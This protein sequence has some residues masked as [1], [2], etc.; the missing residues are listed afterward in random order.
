LF[1]DATLPPGLIQAYRETHYKVPGLEL[2]LVIDQ[3][4]PALELAHH[5]HRADCSA[6]ITACNPYSAEL[7]PAENERRQR[8]LAEE[9]RSRS[10]SFADGVGQHP[11]NG[12]AGEPSF[13]VFG[14]TL[15]AAKS[16][17]IRLEQN[18]FVWSGA[19]AVPRLILLK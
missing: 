18:G 8:H 3:P 9:L 14:L 2:T 4:N 6:F 12:W 15:E 5:R 1:S 13:L 7:T 17:C 10:L 11:S 16:L 19:D